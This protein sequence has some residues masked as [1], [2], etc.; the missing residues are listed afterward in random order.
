LLL[1]LLHSCHFYSSPL[2]HFYNH[3]H[4]T[5]NWEQRQQIIALRRLLNKLCRLKVHQCHCLDL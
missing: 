4:L 1:S 2:P 3:L 5:G